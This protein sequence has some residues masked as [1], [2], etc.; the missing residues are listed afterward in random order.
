MTSIDLPGLTP[1]CPCRFRAAVGL[2]TQLPAESRLRWSGDWADGCA[3]LTSEFD[4]IESLA[5]HLVGWEVPAWLSAKDEHRMVSNQ[6]REQLTAHPELWSVASPDV[7]R[8]SSGVVTPTPWNV[9]LFKGNKSW[10]AALNKVRAAVNRKRYIECLSDRT[11]PVTNCATLGWLPAAAQEEATQG[12]SLTDLKPHGP[13]TLI[14]L[15]V[16]SQP[17]YALWSRGG[18][19]VM[20]NWDDGYYYATWRRPKALSTIRRILS[21]V[22]DDAAMVRH[23]LTLRWYSPLM[24]GAL[25]SASPV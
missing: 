10:L 15:A 5:E 21:G 4:S 24:D 1:E 14:W 9:H 16:L 23:N 11:P 25:G 22:I 6:W 19:L 18:K 13:P 7:V 2:M 8:K 3:V 12:K 20:S 17:L